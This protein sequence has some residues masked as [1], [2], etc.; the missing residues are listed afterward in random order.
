M[1]KISFWVNAVPRSL[2]AEKKE[3]YLAEIKKAASDVFSAPLKSPRLD[4]DII[5][6]AKNRNL[7]ADVDNVAKPILD[8][9]KGIVYEDDKQVRSVRIVALPLD[10]AFRIGGPVS[11]EAFLRLLKCEDFLV[12]VK[13]GLS[14]PVEF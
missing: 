3:N 4:V 2:A 5:F 7:R 10:D 11:H 9:L 13:E 14:L 12:I 8:A 1:A 6:A